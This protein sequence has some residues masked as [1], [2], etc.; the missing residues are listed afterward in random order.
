V[1]KSEDGV[2][3]SDP[4][5]WSNGSVAL[6][7]VKLDQDR[8]QVTASGSELLP[9]EWAAGNLC[10]TLPA[11]MALALAFVVAGLWIVLRKRARK[12]A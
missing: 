10:I 11:G 12:V 5:E 7:R 3:Q 4:L 1:A 2:L 9:L 6:Y 8:V